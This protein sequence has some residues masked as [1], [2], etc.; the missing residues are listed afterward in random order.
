MKTS[1]DTGAARSHG[2]QPAPSQATSVPAPSPAPVEKK[3]NVI[4]SETTWLGSSASSS[5]NPFVT[6]MLTSAKV[7]PAPAMKRKHSGTSGVPRSF[8][9]C[10]VTAHTPPSTTVPTTSHM[11]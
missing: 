1:D 2:Y 11:T 9:Q 5:L 6:R 3:L 8:A 7:M 4:A 10:R